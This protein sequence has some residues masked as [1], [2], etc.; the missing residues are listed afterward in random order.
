MEAINRRKFLGIMGVGVL[1]AT[2]NPTKIMGLINKNSNKPNIIYILADDLGY[3]DLGCYGQKR[4]K[5][6]NIDKM[7]KEGMLFTDHYAGCTVCAPSRCSLMTGV[8]TGHTYI[9]G[10]SNYSETSQL[11]IPDSTKTVAEYLKGAGYRTG[12]IGK[13]GLGGPGTSGLPTKQGFDYFFGYLDQRH[14]HNYYPEYLYR[15]ETKIRL[16]GN[17]VGNPRPDG[18]GVSVKRTQYSHNLFAEE[19]LQFIDK[20]KANPFFLYFALTIPHA[21]NRGG[22]N[23]MDIGMEVPD[24]GEYADMDWP[25]AEKGK[26]AMI[27]RMDKDIGKLLNKLKELGIAENTI[28]IFT[29]DNGPHKEGGAQPEF[30]NSSGPLRGIKRDMYEGGIRVPMIA[31]CPGTIKPNSKSHHVSAF[32]DFLPTA[33]DIGKVNPPK[34]TD[35][36]SFLPE[37]LGQRQKEHEYLYWEY[38]EREDFKQAVRIGKY[39][40]V[41]S[42]EN[43]SW[44]MYDLENDLS[45]TTDISQEHPE[46]IARLKDILLTVRTESEHWK[47]PEER[48]RSLN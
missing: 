46:L 30:S 6:P 39:K 32:W 33:C 38:Y 36:I 22:D 23:G 4:I 12:L 17:K 15:N 35:G 2:L 1:G 47:T 16:E 42:G 25:F 29:S 20:N 27:T 21:N 5:T 34:E 31:W 18:E 43:Y 9:R 28:V 48:K 26:A 19:A 44:E 14:A 7:A 13:W 11:P 37:L 41:K 45:E 10:N 40:F 3:G 24:L 8:H